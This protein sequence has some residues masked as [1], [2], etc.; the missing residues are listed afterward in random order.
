MRAKLAA[1]SS[2]TSR[3][4]GSAPPCPRA[5]L[6]ARG[7]EGQESGQQVGSREVPV[8]GRATLALGGEEVGELCRGAAIDGV[9][10]RVP[11]CGLESERLH[12][13]V[14]AIERR[15]DPYRS[16]ASTRCGG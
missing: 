12:P 15:E 14:V 5:R 9:V 11:G 8:G 6:V 16:S 2:A 10:D 1:S 3:R 4:G 13:R 7:G